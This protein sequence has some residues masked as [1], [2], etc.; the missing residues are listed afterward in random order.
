MQSGE[1]P[2][3]LEVCGE[4][5]PALGVA[6]AEVITGGGS[7]VATANATRIF[8]YWWT[9]G[10]GG[11][12][13]EHRQLFEG[14]A[15]LDVWDRLEGPGCALLFLVPNLSR[16][17]YAGAPG[18]REVPVSGSAAIRL[19]GQGGAGMAPHAADPRWP[20]TGRLGARVVPVV[21]TVAADRAKSLMLGADFSRSGA[22]PSHSRPAGG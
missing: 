8:E 2:H 21:G 18:E 6:H 20:R 12:K 9:I 17:A 16:G 3:Y 5:E 11:S 15:K 13:P 14:G 19:D 4:V 7:D 22:P 10:H 1:H